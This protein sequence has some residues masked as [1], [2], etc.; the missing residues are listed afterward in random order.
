MSTS[1]FQVS[2]TDPDCGV[3]AMVNYTLGEGFG[4]QSEFRVKSATG[5]I[6]ITS[7][8][9]YETRNVYEFPIVATDRG[10]CVCPLDDCRISVGTDGP[11]VC[12]CARDVNLAVTMN[13]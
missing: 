3:N 13:Q 12:M 11:G 7:E 5:E 1:S 8:L 4:K 6:C 10:E 2:A 9:D